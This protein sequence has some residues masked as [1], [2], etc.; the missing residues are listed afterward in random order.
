MH[1]DANLDVVIYYDFSRDQRPDKHSIVPQQL[2]KTVEL[3]RWF[4]STLEAR[5]VS[6]FG[7]RAGLSLSYQ[8]E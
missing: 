4:R 6:K 3:A 1:V 8:G 7:Q 5:V 2:Q